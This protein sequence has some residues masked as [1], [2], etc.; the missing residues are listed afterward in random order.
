MK[1]KYYITTL[2]F[3]LFITNA[4]S[5]DLIGN[6]VVDKSIE[7]IQ[8]ANTSNDSSSTTG[9]ICFLSS[10]NCSSYIYLGNS[11]EVGENYPMMVNSAVGALHISTT[12][13]KINQ[14]LNV[15]EISDFT[16]MNLA[17]ESGGEIG[18]A[19]PMASGQFRVVRFSTIGAVSTIRQVMSFPSSVKSKTNSDEML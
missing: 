1:I 14:E 11:C 9:V 3:S 6:W 10:K 19:V 4:F 5:A 13:V 8:L 15:Y 2:I 7:G 12:C 17:Y 18:F 16:T